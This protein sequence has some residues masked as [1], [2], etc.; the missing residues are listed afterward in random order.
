[1]TGDGDNDAANDNTISQ[2]VKDWLLLL[3]D[4]KGTWEGTQQTSS[5]R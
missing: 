3:G 5:K 4:D 1:M 2:T